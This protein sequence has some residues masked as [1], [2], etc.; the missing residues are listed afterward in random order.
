[1][2]IE[3]GQKIKSYGQIETIVEIDIKNDMYF[4]EH[5]ICVPDE[6]YTKDWICLSEIEE[7]IC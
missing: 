6:I 7:I 1:M 3:I 4:L 5:P 2:K